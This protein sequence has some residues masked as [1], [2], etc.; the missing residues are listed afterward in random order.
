VSKT[1]RIEFVP[2]SGSEAENREGADGLA[3]EHAT[4]LAEQFGIELGSDEFASL[5]NKLA[6]RYQECGE[7]YGYFQHFAVRLVQT[8]MNSGHMYMV[9]E[10]HPT[11]K[12]AIHTLQT[13]TQIVTSA[14]MWMHAS[15]EVSWIPN[16]QWEEIDE[17]M[18]A[19]RFEF[20]TN[21]TCNTE[22][23]DHDHD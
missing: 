9:T 2:L 19:V 10:P 15:Q 23:G 6:P 13:V 5:Y 18:R 14:L 1:L 4:M 3:W 8:L 11:D 16:A 20:E 17:D 7:H 21:C 12:D 22:E